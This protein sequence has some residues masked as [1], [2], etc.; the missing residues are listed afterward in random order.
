MA[1]WR[2]PRCEREFARTNQ[3]HVCVP[4]GTVAETFA[5]RP[6][7][8]R[9]A[10]EAVM[11]HLRTLGP[12]HVDA[13]GVGVFLKSDRKFAEVRPMARALSLDIMAIHAI[14]HP[15]VL[16]SQ[17]IGADRVWSV[18]RLHGPDDVDDALKAAL[19]IAYDDATD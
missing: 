11:A 4:G 5:G 15:L 14:A 13:V 17:R 2:C 10:Y 3:S 7:Y 19:T 12:V 18:I 8:Q 9:A 16:R 6:E 1:R